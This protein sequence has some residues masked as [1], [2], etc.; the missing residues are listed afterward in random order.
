M[1]LTNCLSLCDF[2]KGIFLMCRNY[3]T[4]FEN[5]LPL[6]RS[7]VDLHQSQTGWCQ[8]GKWQRAAPHE[9]NTESV[10][11]C[12]RCTT[13][14]PV[15]HPERVEKVWRKDSCAKWCSPSFL[16]LVLIFLL[17][18]S[19]WWKRRMKLTVFHIAVRSIACAQFWPKLPLILHFQA[20]KVNT[21]WLL[22]LVDF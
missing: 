13:K 10:P 2:P 12:Q 6:W 22:P 21:V 20:E 9:Q 16:P 19:A 1:K 18:L 15:W 4:E 3:L 8:C 5:N 14:G 11:C 7:E 17:I